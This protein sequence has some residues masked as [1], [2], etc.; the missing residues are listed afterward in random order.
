[1]GL[2]AAPEFELW[3]Q[4]MGVFAAGD[5]SKLLDQMPAPF[6]AVLARLEHA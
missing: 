2:R 6:E 5:A 1:M 4:S 3:L